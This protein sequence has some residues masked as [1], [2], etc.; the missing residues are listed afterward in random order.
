M[1]NMCVKARWDTLILRSII[2][3]Y[4]GFLSL[5]LIVPSVNLVQF[6]KRAQNKPPPP[7]KKEMEITDSFPLMNRKLNTRAIRVTSFNRTLCATIQ[8]AMSSTRMTK[9]LKRMRQ[10]QR[11][12]RS[13][14]LRSNVSILD[15]VI[16][17]IMDNVSRC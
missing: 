17:N 12:T 2:S 14:K 15:Y 5:L 8:K 1:R 3:R 7:K 9:I 6:Q 10:R 4:I 13:L 11:R 16:N